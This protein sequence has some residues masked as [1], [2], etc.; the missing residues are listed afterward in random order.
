MSHYLIQRHTFD[1][2]FDE[3]SKATELQDKI[4]RIFN[5]DLM[6]ELHVLFNRL[7]PADL[8]L[9]LDK[10]N[11]DAGIINYDDVDHLLVDHI[12][13][14]L[15]AELRSAINLNEALDGSRAVTEGGAG[16][17]KAGYIDMLEYYL[18][19]GAFPWWGRGLEVKSA[20]QLIEKLISED[21]A[22]LKAMLMVT[23][24]SVTVQKRIA[25][26]F[27][28]TVIKQIITVLEPVNAGFIIRY[29]AEITAI[30]QRGNIVKEESSHFERIVWEF[31]LSTLLTDMS[32]RFNRKMFVKSNIGLIAARFNLSYQQL[33][34]LLHQSG[35]AGELR[36]SHYE[37]F[38]LVDELWTDDQGGKQTE[39][40]YQLPVDEDHIT[41]RAK[42][43]YQHLETVF[44]FL[45]HGSF[46]NNFAIE[47]QRKLNELFIESIDRVP[48][49]VK[50]MLDAWQNTESPGER[51]TAIFDTPSIVKIIRLIEPANAD[52][53]ID[54]HAGIAKIQQ[55]KPLVNV[56]HSGFVKTVWVL[57]LDY[58]FIERGS[59][60]NRK[61]FLK[62]NIRNIANHYNISIGDLVST[63]KH[64][65]RVAVKTSLMDTFFTALNEISESNPYQADAE[66]IRQG[67]QS[68]FTKPI[69]AAEIYD[70]YSGH[71]VEGELIKSMPEQAGN[72]T[73]S[74]TRLRDVL[75]FWLKN[76]KLPWWYRQTNQPPQYIFAD[77]VRYSPQYIAQ[78]FQFAGKIS[79][80]K[81]NSVL[82][83]PAVKLLLD[84]VSTEVLLKAFSLLPQG[85][86]AVKAYDD[87]LLLLNKTTI[88]KG[89]QTS[90][91]KRILL[92]SLFIFYNDS[93][94]QSFN[95]VA[96]LHIVLQ[97]LALW[98]AADAALIYQ[99]LSVSLIAD[100]SFSYLEAP[101]WQLSKSK[102]VQGGAGKLINAIPVDADLWIKEM[103]TNYINSTSLLTH[104]GSTDEVN[105]RS[106]EDLLITIL[107]YFLNHHQMP[108]SL[109]LSAR[110][111]DAFLKYLIIYLYQNKRSQLQQLFESN[112]GRITARIR[113]HNLFAVTDAQGS[114][115][116]KKMLNRFLETDLVKYLHE[117][118]PSDAEAE[119]VGFL[120]LFHRL[121]KD[122]PA[123]LTLLN[124]V[125]KHQSVINYLAINY[126]DRQVNELIAQKYR[127]LGTDV[128]RFLMDVHIFFNS[129]DKGLSNILSTKLRGFNLFYAFNSQQFDQ[130]AYIN[131]LFDNFNQYLY[132]L[133][134]DQI[135]ALV[136]AP[137]NQSKTS[138]SFHQFF[139]LF[140][141]LLKRQLVR[142]QGYAA[143][144]NGLLN[145][146]IATTPSPVSEQDIKAE[147]MKKE[148]TD[149]N[150]EPM[151]I[152]QLPEN[153][154]FTIKNAGLVILHPFLS[155]YFNTLKMT[156]NGDF[157]N[158]EVRQRAVH[159][160]QYL[161]DNRTDAP[162]TD[163]LLNKIMAGLPLE[164]SVPEKIELTDAEKTLSDQLFKALIN[165]WDK[166]KNSS[167]EG[168]QGS[169]L[170]RDGTLTYSDESWHLSVEPRGYD[171]LLQT[172]PWGLGMIKTTWMKNMLT[173]KWE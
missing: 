52:F 23:G 72:K 10:L 112:E 49:T 73:S 135:R 51:I 131:I 56:E 94:Y 12:I 110:Q 77:L 149:Y 86:T 48:G 8:I 43:L 164:E 39:M 173:V 68:S 148:L 27:P 38:G 71:N 46:A 115:Q 11:I 160:L 37:L 171:I 90:V 18:N 75:L 95:I 165:N 59:E 147:L 69:S 128:V 137:L 109:N 14:A 144:E 6:R 54:Y 89:G 28:V 100:Q 103:L 142:L 163:L 96:Y 62:S 85:G 124:R 169:F 143:V 120:A 92:Y 21:A 167:V 105:R 99:E 123:F 130:V 80:T 150:D 17:F 78:V 81:S 93:G 45:N 79:A 153:Q 31:I 156:D 20:T 154:S 64:T 113:I 60:F 33:L 97:Q 42:L 118:A 63:L 104:Q 22:G 32:G 40:A 119:G 155:F 106:I 9:Q 29:H 35:Q 7:V 91:L 19:F 138:P 25:M 108:A 141:E 30:Q 152:P 122:L 2:T 36:E 145:G 67:K 133:T 55:E 158:D 117:I 34:G 83:N 3:Q 74:G 168:V 125:M 139:N 44:Y 66:R 4:S 126:T 87:L 70:H 26:Q 172:L 134:S 98:F 107:K 53:I 47:D 15:E 50:E 136:N 129:T 76:N 159:L 5:E 146:Q 88:L 116:V 162:E 58:L 57:I 61:S 82:V 121:T 140:K 127:R 161:V 111:A 1:L 114:E 166:L 24:R 170:Q 102:S 157:I 84:S 16:R 151:L 65:A 41:S 101:L 13:E 132:Q